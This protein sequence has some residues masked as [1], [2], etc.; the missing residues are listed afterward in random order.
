MARKPTTRLTVECLETRDAPSVAQPILASIPAVQS[1]FVAIPAQ[2]QTSVP[3]AVQT[4]TLAALTKVQAGHA[5]T[6]LPANVVDAIGVGY[7]TGIAGLR[8]NHNQ[9][10]VR[11][12]V[13]KRRRF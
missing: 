1:T 8:P 13:R 12:G 5:I 10:L 2:V 9:T 11:I 6:P 4:Q 7:S 3:T